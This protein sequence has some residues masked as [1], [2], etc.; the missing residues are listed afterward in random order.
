MITIRPTVPEDAGPLAAL[1]ARTFQET[2]GAANDPA[3]MALHLASA[4]GLAQQSRELADPAMATLVAEADG[5]LAG[6]A[7]LREGAAPGCV[8]GA[9]PIELLRFYVDAPWQGRGLAQALMDAV[10]RS[11]AD[12][13]RRTLW[14][15]VWER[16]ERAQAFYRKCGFRKVGTQVFVVGT[17][18][19]TDHVMLREFE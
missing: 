10:R 9:A 12:R 3:D 14:L 13:G 15:G 4:Y 16:N 5:R 17:D 19:Q 6:F 18:P 2:F 1:A 11:A 8:A 7:Q